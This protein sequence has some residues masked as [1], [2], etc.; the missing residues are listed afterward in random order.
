LWKRNL[1]RAT[2]EWRALSS[3]LGVWPRT[4]TSQCTYSYT[5]D[6]DSRLEFANR[7][8]NVN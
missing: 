3:P 7:L 5:T 6:A 4:V 1:A 8:S 2:R